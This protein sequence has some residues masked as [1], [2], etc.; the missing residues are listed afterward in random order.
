MDL[1][2]AKPQKNK[3]S[4]MKKL[5]TSKSALESVIAHLNEDEVN[6][7][8]FE[9]IPETIF[10]C[11]F[12]NERITHKRKILFIAQFDFVEKIDQTQQQYLKNVF[13]KLSQRIYA[14]N[15]EL[16][17][18]LGFKWL[19]HDDWGK[20]KKVYRI[21]IGFYEENDSEVIQI[22]LCKKEEFDNLCQSFHGLRFVK[23][24]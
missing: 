24:K 12:K 18:Q 15:L 7:Q 17:P 3:L 19:H 2:T 22:F 13:S 23:E 21:A 20:K 16:K 9:N 5:P 4:K 11:K 14:S 1:T 8:I 6:F 10:P